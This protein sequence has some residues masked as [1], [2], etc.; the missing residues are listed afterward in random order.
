MLKCLILIG[1]EKLQ[2][3]VI[4]FRLYRRRVAKKNQMVGEAYLKGCKIGPHSIHLLK[5]RGPV[6]TS[7]KKVRLLKFSS[8]HVQFNVFLN[9]EHLSIQIKNSNNKRL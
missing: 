3:S 5:I 9:P 6:M 1:S 2:T 8:K 4:R 7:T